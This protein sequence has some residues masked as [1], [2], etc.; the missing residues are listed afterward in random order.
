MPFF[1]AHSTESTILQQNGVVLH[2]C[3]ENATLNSNICFT[4]SQKQRQRGGKPERE[5]RRE[6][7]RVLESQNDPERGNHREQQWATESCRSTL[8]EK[9]QDRARMQQRARDS[10]REYCHSKVT[11]LCTWTLIKSDWKLEG[12][13]LTILGWGTS[14]ELELKMKKWVFLGIVLIHLHSS[15]IWKL[16][17][18]LKGPVLLWMVTLCWILYNHTDHTETLRLHHWISIWSHWL[19]LNMLPPC[20]CVFSKCF[21][22]ASW[23]HCSHL[24]RSCGKITKLCSFIVQKYKLK[25]NH[26]DETCWPHL[27][28][29]LIQCFK[30]T[31]HWSHLYLIHSWWLGLCELRF[32]DWIALFSHW[33]HLYLITPC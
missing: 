21:W 29:T 20:L 27:F 8:T 30:T 10:P 15:T 14:P 3:Y 32:Y 33:L 23:S 1:L 9:V 17:S 13:L 16:F 2:N 12:S 5:D 4:E 18:I 24:N 11:G 28:V 26:Q 25:R 22:V 6:Q 19:H 7:E 31:L